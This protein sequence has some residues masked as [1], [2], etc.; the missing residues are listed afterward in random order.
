V[1]P[2]MFRDENDRAARRSAKAKA[3]TEARRRLED[4]TALESDIYT[5]GS[6]DD[7]SPSDALVC[8]SRDQLIPTSSITAP[9]SIPLDGQ[10]LRFFVDRFVTRVVTRS[11]GSPHVDF[12][13]PS[14]HVGV[15]TLDQASRDALV[16]VG[17]AA[18]SNVNN[19]RGL[20]IM[21]REKHAMVIKAVREVVENPT[22]ANSDRTLHLI[23][24]LSLYEVGASSS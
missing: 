23:V 3:K 12:V 5:P 17:L 14:P 21:S 15:V 18:L 16:S 19:D 1:P 7:C 9:M 13:Q 4:R 6:R 2:F 22:Q 24:M 11:D 20:R 8:R 10:G